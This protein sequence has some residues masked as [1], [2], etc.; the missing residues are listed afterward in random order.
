MESLQLTRQPIGFANLDVLSLCLDVD[1]VLWVGTVAGLCQFKN[2]KW[3]T[4]TT[5][6]GLTNNRIR[7]ILKDRD[8][9]LWIGTEGGGINR[10]CRY[11]I[12]PLILSMMA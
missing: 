9:N 1:N 7:S 8:G 2:G 4:F 10:M 6:D 12:S 5:K 3:T 11:I